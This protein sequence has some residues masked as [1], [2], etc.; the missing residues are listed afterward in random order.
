LKIEGVA[1]RLDINDF[2][3]NN[4]IEEYKKLIEEIENE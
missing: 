3:K 2:I 1:N 4:I